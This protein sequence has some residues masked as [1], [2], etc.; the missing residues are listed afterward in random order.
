M[1]LIDVNRETEF[2]GLTWAGHVSLTGKERS[3]LKCKKLYLKSEFAA[4]AQR[5]GKQQSQ[6]RSPEKGIRRS[7]I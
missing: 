4:V 3:G 5:Q 1:N 2:E 6:V 7:D